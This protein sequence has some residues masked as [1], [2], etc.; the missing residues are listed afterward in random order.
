MR[1]MLYN[2]AFAVSTTSLY[3]NFD[4]L[5]AR[6]ALLSASSSIHPLIESLRSQASLLSVVNFAKGSSIQT[7]ALEVS[8]FNLFVWLK[9]I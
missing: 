2:Q 3:S 6:D 4:T 1:S 7:T 8:R 9:W 5:S